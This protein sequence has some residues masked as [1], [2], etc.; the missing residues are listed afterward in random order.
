MEWVTTTAKT[1]PEAIDLAL[2]NLGVDESEAEI[3]VLEEP[4]K[5]LFGRTRGT[6]RVEARVK[7]KAIR[8]KVERSRSRRS[9]SKD[10]NSRARS[11]R[12][13]RGGRSRNRSGNDSGGG[14]PGGDRGRGRE[15][16]DDSGK[17]QAN[18][19]QSGQA[20]DRSG[21][22]GRGQDSS[23]TE[24]AESASTVNADAGGR[25]H[26]SSRRGANGGNDGRAN[27][28]SNGGGGG[29]NNRR[30]RGGRSRPKKSS[31]D[32][33]AG[34]TPTNEQETPVE[35][36]EEHLRTFLGGLTE[37]FGLDG[38]VD[39]ERSDSDVLVATVKAQHGLMV[40]PKGRTL[41]AIQELAR[42]S[43]QRAAP[44]SL[45]IRVDVGGYRRQRAEALA[46]F[47]SQAADK[48]VD[49][50]REVALDP[51]SPTDRKSVHDALVDDDR[52]ETRS[53]GTEPR[54]R[55]IVIPVADSPSGSDE[56]E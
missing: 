30:D 49:N 41:D 32:K 38:G 46:G 54:R 34:N 15:R 52:V 45:R 9:K 27:Q 40:G 8:P 2:D 55:V 11:D 51:M 33:I 19:G 39:I 47:A 44:S 24:A 5:G 36:V 20:R 6:A 12:S 14:G 28:G 18:G 56:E 50:G 4:S 48:A 16:G 31:G 23:S 29:G 13:G 26:G 17:S 37:A 53:V 25:E 43:S 42:V 21:G 10:S 3:V 22:G 35:E 7:P 1:L